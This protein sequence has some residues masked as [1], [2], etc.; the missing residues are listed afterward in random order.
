[1][2]PPQ[3]PTPETEAPRSNKRRKLSGREAP[4]ATQTTHANQLADVADKDFY[5]PE[6]SIEER[7]AVRKDFR[8][9]SRELTGG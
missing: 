5:D 4:S 1:M 3:L 7:R 6:Q 2:P 8:D 9:L